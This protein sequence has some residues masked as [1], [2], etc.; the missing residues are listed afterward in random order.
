MMRT[1]DFL[2]AVFKSPR[3]TGG[4]NRRGDK[5]ARPQADCLTCIFDERSRQ[6]LIEF[7]GAAG[8]CDLLPVIRP[9][10]PP[11]PPPRCAAWID[12]AARLPGARVRKSPAH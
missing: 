9:A 5:P 10:T 1:I 2:H 6:K 7:R 11:T 3:K 8:N 4:R 12:D